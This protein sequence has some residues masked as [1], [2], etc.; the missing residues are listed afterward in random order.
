[1]ARDEATFKSTI[2]AIKLR[3]PLRFDGKLDE[4]VYEQFKG[5]G[6]MLQVAP[7]YNQP[8]T[9]RTEIW[10][11]FDGDNIYVAGALLGHR[12]ARQVDRQRAAPRHQPDAQQRSLRRRLRHLLRSAQ[13]L[14]VLR[15]S[16]WAASRITR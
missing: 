4:P 15:Q 6:G 16:R 12:A 14:H 8:S 11:L 1:M 7:R 9:E 5:F 13:R 3:E 10:V 2:R